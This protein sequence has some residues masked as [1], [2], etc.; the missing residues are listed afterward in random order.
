MPR[1][2]IGIEL[3]EPIK[4]AALEAQQGYPAP[5]WQA[6]QQLH[7]TLRFLGAVEQERLPALERALRSVRAE[8]FE[9]GVA[10]V[11]CFGEPDSPRILWA[12]VSAQEPLRRLREQIDRSLLDLALA[13]PTSPYCPHVTLARLRPPAPSA[14][15]WLAAYQSLSSPSARV[16]EFSLVAS[17]PTAEGSRY[18]CVQRFGLLGE[19]G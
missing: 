14:R 5:R 10:G 18:S 17:L 2:F 9:L 12:G 1:L 8:P 3:A 19:E 6:A 13:Y 16:T 15:A 7:L 11:G 4:R